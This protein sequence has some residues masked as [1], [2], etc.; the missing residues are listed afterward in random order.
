[1]VELWGVGG[2]EGSR[3]EARLNES[4]ASGCA[5]MP[6]PRLIESLLSTDN[7]TKLMVLY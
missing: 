4:C 3:V 5:H 7:P 1:M 2:W 6:S